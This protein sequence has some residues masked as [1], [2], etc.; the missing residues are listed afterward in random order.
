MKRLIVD[1]DECGEEHTATYSHEGSYGEGAIYAV[2]C[3]DWLTDYYTAERVRQ[4]GGNC[5]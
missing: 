2:V 1:C 3:A 4:C 5:P